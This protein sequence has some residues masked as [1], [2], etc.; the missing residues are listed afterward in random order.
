MADIRELEDETQAELD[1]VS[2][3]FGFPLCH[4]HTRLGLDQSH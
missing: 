2:K 4:E 3:S 1:K